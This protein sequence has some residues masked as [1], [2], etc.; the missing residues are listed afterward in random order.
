MSESDGTDGKAPT[1][2][3]L[4]QA[5]DRGRAGDKVPWPDPAAAPLG[6]DDEAAGAAPAR[7]ELDRSYQAETGRAPAHTPGGGS[8]A[9]WIGLAVAGIV[10]VG[11]IW[12]IV[13]AA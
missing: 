7:A 4:R 9:L 5:I 11:G 3:Q 8:A 13:A 1:V 6:T 12:M 10:V 2:A